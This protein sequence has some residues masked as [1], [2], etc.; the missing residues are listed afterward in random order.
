ML[1]GLK[2]KSQLD[3]QPR[4]NWSGEGERSNALEKLRVLKKKRDK[5][6]TTAKEENSGVRYRQKA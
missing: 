1:A 6:G 3:W 5:K 4:A 2:K